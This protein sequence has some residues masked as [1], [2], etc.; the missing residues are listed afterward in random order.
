M[1][2]YGNTL[3]L[4]FFIIAM[5]VLFFSSVSYSRL[6]TGTYAADS[7]IKGT[8]MQDVFAQ[9]T[10]SPDDAQQTSSP[11]DAQQ[12][13]SPDDAQQTSSPD[14]A[15]Q[16]SSPDDA[17]N[18]KP[19]ADAGPDQTVRS[20]EK[21]TLD[22]TDSKASSLD[23]EWER[24]D[25][26]PQINNWD[27]FGRNEAKPTFTA[28]SVDK[29]T[30]LT[31]SLKVY[32]EYEWS[33]PDRVT[34]TVEP[35]VQ[36]GLVKADAGPPQ[37]VTSEDEVTLDASGSKGSNLIYEWER[38]DN[39]PQINNWGDNDIAQVKP[40]FTAPTVDKPIELMFDLFVYDEKEG[41]AG[42]DDAQVTITVE[43]KVA[44]PPPSNQ[45]AL[46]IQV[47]QD[48]IK[49]GKE[50]TI[51][52]TAID[53]NS[54]ENINNAIINGMVTY[55]N[56]YTKKFSEE[57]GEIIYHWQIKSNTDPGQF[58]VT[59]DVSA[60][61]YEAGHGSKTFD[62]INEEGP[63][64]NDPTPNDPTPNDP[65]PNDPTPNDPTPNDP[66][67]NDPT[68]NDP[69]PNG[70]SIWIIPVSILAAIALGIAYAAKHKHP[71]K[72]PASHVEVMTQGGIEEH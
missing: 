5:V 70:N 53:K 36:V 50:Q 21:V 47:K 41:A 44:D 17:Q 32:D 61:G 11:D 2:K 71:E 12:T 10:S 38:T 33:D 18:K 60:D 67:P 64:P 15:Q 57:D 14:D 45:L 62:V 27:S 40:S 35:K 6:I 20:E 55:S 28:P 26:G 8:V 9:Q 49:V 56:G 46:E 3:P 66:T 63:T 22:G 48:P 25:N 4:K 68:P 13:S 31:F 37:T 7:L 16:T 54:S 30:K 43:P 24:T 29:I 42:G 51:T 34:I 72:V 52:I 69:T 19:K 1:L 39:G 65:T 58:T 59:A 23:Y